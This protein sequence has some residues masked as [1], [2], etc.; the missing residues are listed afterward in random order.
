MSSQ[1]T[2]KWETIASNNKYHL[3]LLQTY[4]LFKMNLELNFGSIDRVP[5]ILITYY[6]SSIN[7]YINSLSRGFV[8]Y[9]NIIIDCWMWVVLSKYE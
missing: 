2:F 5:T 9:L 3:I 4:I 1:V 8:Y 6:L 7:I